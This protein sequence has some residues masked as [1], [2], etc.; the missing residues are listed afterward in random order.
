MVS[1]LLNKEKEAISAEVII[2]NEAIRLYLLSKLIISLSKK[3]WLI[4]TVPVKIA[5]KIIIVNM[6]LNL[7]IHSFEKCGWSIR[8][9]KINKI[10]PEVNQNSF[11]K[12]LK[13]PE[14]YLPTPTRSKRDSPKKINLVLLFKLFP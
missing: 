9:S 4:I 5:N 3:I 11:S 12:K 8:E 7:I 10:K 13:L 6:I 1:L 2:P 14:T